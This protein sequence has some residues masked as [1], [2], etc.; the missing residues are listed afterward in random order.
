MGAQAKRF[1][2]QNL[3]TGSRAR[4]AIY[5]LKSGRLYVM[6]VY[7]TA[8]AALAELLDLLKPYPEDSPWRERIVVR[9]TSGCRSSGPKGKR[10]N[11]AE[12]HEGPCGEVVWFSSSGGRKVTV[13][14]PQK[15]K[16]PATT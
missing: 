4:Y 3:A 13:W 7:P 9:E 16:D 1:E 15:K 6:A 12:G 5:D 11:L 8:E 2:V 14:F 10:C